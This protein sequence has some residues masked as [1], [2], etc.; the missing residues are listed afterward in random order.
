M[1]HDYIYC[2]ITDSYIY[3]IYKRVY[4]EKDRVDPF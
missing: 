3:K 4:S 2:N 1:F